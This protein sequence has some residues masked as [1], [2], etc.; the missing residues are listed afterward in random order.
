MR[1]PQEPQV[2]RVRKVS[3]QQQVQVRAPEQGP[4][5]LLLQEQERV[6]RELQ[7]QVRV[8]QGPQPEPVPHK[9]TGY[10]SED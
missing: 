8:Q 6:Q 7:Q 3:A 5:E 2:L 4:R 10:T 9:Q 1:V